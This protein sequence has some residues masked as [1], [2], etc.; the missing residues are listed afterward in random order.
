MNK[1]INILIIV[2]IIIFSNALV[3]C[4]RVDDFK[5]RLG[6]KNKDFEYIN[7]GRISKVTI[8]NKRD[9]GYTFIITDKDA[10][11]ELYDILSKAKEVENKITLD[12]DYMLEFHEGVNKV[13]K[14]NY[15]AGLDKKD[16]GN[17]YSDDK[18]YIVS[19]RLDDDIMKNFWNIR[20]PNK[21]KEVYYMSM[22]KA[23]EDYRKSLG[24][25]KKIGIDISDEEVAKFILTMDIEEFKEGLG[26]KEELITDDDRNKYDVTMDIK[27]QGYKTDIYKCII[28][29]F[30]KETKKETKYYFV[31][32]Y[33]LNFWKFNFTKDKEPENF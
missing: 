25:D 14:F 16:L 12:S 2:L 26:S 17:L 8:Q 23:I 9:K 27:T 20:K 22:N 33:D 5:V 19:K 28:T 1:R 11:K 21:F 7:E 32:K 3:G 10:I 6:M 13:Y 18:I 29:F 30:N 4:K 24:K 31:N 15:V